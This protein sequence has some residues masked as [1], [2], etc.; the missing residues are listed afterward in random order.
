MEV[1]VF[2]IF[3][4]RFWISDFRLATAAPN[5]AIRATFP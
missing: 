4:F 3:D 1:M 5:P 2:L